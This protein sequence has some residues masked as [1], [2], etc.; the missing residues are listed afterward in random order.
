M[1]HLTSHQN[2]QYGLL[3]TLLLG[4]AAVA[5]ACGGDANPTPSPP[6]IGSGGSSASGGSGGSN[7]GKGGSGGSG[8]NT[9]EGGA[10]NEGGGNVET[11]GTGGSGGSTG[12]SGGN[13]GSTGGTGGSTG[14]NGGST[15]GNGGSTGGNGGSTGGNGGSTGGSAGTG[16]SSVDCDERGERDCYQCTPEAADPEPAF[17]H[18]ANE[19]FLNRCSDADCSFFDNVA[20]IPG[21]TDTD[22]LPS[23]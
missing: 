23:L 2:R 12:G 4:G 15:G 10:A 11:G 20:R 7:G 13:G 6:I 9:A 5:Q 3:V 18:T 14:G 8:N 1:K 22:H 17:P 16:G 21:F 19:Q